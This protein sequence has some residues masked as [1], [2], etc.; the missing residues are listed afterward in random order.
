M[1]SGVLPPE[2]PVPDQLGTEATVNLYN[3]TILNTVFFIIL[4][5]PRNFLAYADSEMHLT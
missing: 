1:V 5:L 4:Q 3:L 2:V